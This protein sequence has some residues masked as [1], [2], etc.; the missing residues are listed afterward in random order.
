MGILE[1]YPLSLGELTGVFDDF[2]DLVF[3]DARPDITSISKKELLE[4]IIIGG[5]PTPNFSIMKNV[6]SGLKIMLQPF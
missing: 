1:L 3:S 5:Y 6:I 2:I 4:K